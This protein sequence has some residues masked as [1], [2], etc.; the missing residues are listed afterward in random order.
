[1][2][3]LLLTSI[4]ADDGTLVKV[5]AVFFIKD[6]KPG[7]YLGLSKMAASLFLIFRSLPV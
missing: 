6:G 2:M 1:M 5:T 3:C 4:R 7:K